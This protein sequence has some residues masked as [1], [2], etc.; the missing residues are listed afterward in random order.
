MAVSRSASYV[1]SS[2]PAMFRFATSSALSSTGRCCQ[3][4]R[5]FS[6]FKPFQQST[7]RQLQTASA[8][9][10][11]AL[12]PPPA[13]PRNKGVP[14]TSIAGAQSEMNEQRSPQRLTDQ[15]LSSLASGQGQRSSIGLAESQAQNPKSAATSTQTST[16]SARPNRLRFRPK[17]AA[18]TLSP[19]AVKQLRTLLDQPEPKMIKVGT[20][21]KGCSGLAYHLEYVDKPGKFDDVV[22]Q[23]GVKVLIDSKALLHILGSEM[24]WQEDKLNARFTFK[25][26]NISEQCGCGES[27]SVS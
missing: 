25:N 18:M 1:S 5:A 22:E 9:H 26:P 3:C 6:S 4:F 17:K 13:P 8:Y 14:E 15:Q 27:F 11:S 19:S 24:D 23:D 16:P 20:R 2:A 10:P 21:S 7:R 12:E